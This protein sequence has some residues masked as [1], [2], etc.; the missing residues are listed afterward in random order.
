MNILLDTH[1]VIWALFDSGKLSPKV[2][3]YLDNPTNE[4][5]YSIVAPW[6]VSIKHA[7]KP[8]AMPVE[9]DKLIELCRETG[10]S[11]LPI[12]EEHI[13]YL[14]QLHYTS[15][16]R[17]ADPF[18]RIMI[19]QAAVENMVLLTHDKRLAHYGEPCVVA[20]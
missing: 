11:R 1:F 4:L 6:E 5:F 3:T 13:L 16:G 10:I 12:F 8:E 9:P 17:H 14:D 2:R 19:C 15:E 20:V 18:D 7:I